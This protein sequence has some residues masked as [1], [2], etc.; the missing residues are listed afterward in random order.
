MDRTI[1][2][3]SNDE[4]VTASLQSHLKRGGY[5]LS[6]ASTGRAALARARAERPDLVIVELASLKAIGRRTYHRLHRSMGI[7]TILIMEGRRADEGMEAEGYLVKPVSQKRL[8]A[9]VRMVLKGKEPRYLRV[10]DLVLD[11]ESRHLAK[12]GKPKKLTPKEFKLLRIL[13][14]NVGDVLSRRILI[15]EVWET[16]YLGDTRTLDVHICW[17]RQKV[18][19]I[20][21]QP[22]YLRT[23]RGVGYVL[24]DP[25][26]S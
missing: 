3:V 1:L 4:A 26:Q 12:E 6:T 18:E 14:R 8:L 15:K 10:G 17:L 9:R 24:E 7:P 20:P 2:L 19:K 22:E 23:L 11:L 25:S 5:Q 16:D 13:M 21:S